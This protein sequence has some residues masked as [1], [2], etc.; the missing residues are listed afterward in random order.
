LTFRDVLGG[1]K[2]RWGIGRSR[3]RIPP[4]LYGLGDPGPDSPVLVTANYKFSFDSL[5][6]ELGGL[7]AWILVLD[8]KGI[9]VW[10]AAGKGTFGTEEIVSRAAEVR[11][12]DVVSHR[13]LVLPQ[14]GAPGV[15]AHEVRGRSGFK[16]V[17]GPVRAKDLPAFLAAGLKARPEMREVRFGLVDRLVL[18]PVEISG[19]A[20]YILM[21]L[22]VLAIL[23]LAG[24][25]ALDPNVLLAVGGA[26][27]AGTFVVPVLLPWIPGRAFAFK[28]WL[29]GWVWAVA[30]GISMGWFSTR[31]PSLPLAL[32]AF[33]ALPAVSAYLAMNFTGS[34]AYTSL[35]GVLKEMRMAIP[36]VVFSVGAGIVC[37]L[38]AL[39][40]KA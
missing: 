1:W 18:T 27:L 40:L 22:G 26:V 36:G 15:A 31:P 33:L 20:G 35:S 14:L 4:G 38:I 30:F 29:V 28:G 7:D 3:Y 32:A 24:I 13:T 19:L 11:L 25:E 9:N 16:V 39:V 10:C 37:V 2:V 8:T 21:F 23:D 34:S 5:R 12:A 6:K 17:Y